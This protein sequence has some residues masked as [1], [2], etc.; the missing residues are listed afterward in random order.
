MNTCRGHWSWSYCSWTSSSSPVC[1]PDVRN[2]GPGHV[3][4]GHSIPSVVWSQPVLFHLQR[5]IFLCLE[6]LQ[7]EDDQKVTVLWCHKGIRV[8][9]YSCSYLMGEAACHNWVARK[10]AHVAA[11]Q[12][13]NLERSNRIIFKVFLN[14]PSAIKS[15]SLFSKFTCAAILYSSIKGSL[16]KWNWRGSSVEIEMLRPLKIE[17]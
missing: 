3:V 4:A 6:I 9:R 17:V 15:L 2:I 7:F 13:P 16:V 12:L 1:N 5:G 10:L 8:S 14:S 11:G